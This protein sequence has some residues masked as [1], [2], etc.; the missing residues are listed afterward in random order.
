MSQNNN[1]VPEKSISERF[2]EIWRKLNHNQRRYVIASLEYP[3]KKEAAE[4]IDIEPDTVYRWP[5]I[6]D[7]AIEF[8]I[9]ETRET[10]IGMLAESLTKAVAVKIAG[11]DSDDE[12]VRHTASTE[13]IDR[14]FG[15]ATQPMEHTG[16]EGGEI[17][18]RI[19]GGVNIDDV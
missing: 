18:I 10:A 19:I 16:A 8:A 14:L 2:S 12:K 17:P 13:I 1:E 9:K 6:V 15:R 5:K 11:L 3:T 4:A 7:E